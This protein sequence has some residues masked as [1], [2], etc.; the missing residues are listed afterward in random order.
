MTLKRAVLLFL[1]EFYR[2]S[3]TVLFYE[4]TVIVTTCIM[5]MVACFVIKFSLSYNVTELIKVYFV[6][7]CSI[8]IFSPFVIPLKIFNIWITFMPQNCV[9]VYFHGLVPEHKAFL[10]NVNTME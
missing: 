1:S 5:K 4:E 8:L 3:S 10:Y 7:V 6:C 2:T 9:P